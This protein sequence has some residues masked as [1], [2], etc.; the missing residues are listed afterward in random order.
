MVLSA[1]RITEIADEEVDRILEKEQYMVDTLYGEGGFI[2]DIVLPG[3]QRLDRYWAVTPD[4]SDVLMLVDPDWESRIRAGLDKGPVNP[5]W[6]N[7]L[8]EPGLLKKMSQ[9]FVRL[10]T[11]H[12]DRYQGATHEVPQGSG[13]Q[14]A[15]LPAGGGL[16]LPMAPTSGPPQPGA[17]G[18]PGGFGAP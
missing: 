14:S 10:N 6:I 8:R 15:P 17:G 13:A 5:Y 12:E 18:Y 2:G 3:P 16:P 9:D 11:Q 1:K 7:L 4:L